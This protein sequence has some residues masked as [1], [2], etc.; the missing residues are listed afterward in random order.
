MCVSFWNVVGAQWKEEIDL[1]VLLPDGD[2]LPVMLLANKCDLENAV[3]NKE[4]LDA[5]CEKHGFV[6]WFNTSAKLNINI[7][8]A[9]KA[10]VEQI[11]KHQ[12]IFM[13]KKNPTVRMNKKEHQC[14]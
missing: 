12:D 1:K 8:V 2:P 14:S 9:A 13:K 11:L 5:F 10:L 7:D 6:G 3:V 4:E